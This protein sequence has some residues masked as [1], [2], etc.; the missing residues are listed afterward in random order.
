MY[1]ISFKPSFI[2]QTKHLEKNLLALLY[3]KMELLKD[4]QNHRVLKIH[5]LHGPL[6]GF[7]SFSLNY[8][9]R[10]IFEFISQN[11]IVLVAMGGHEIYK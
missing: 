3:K 4:S 8:K 6:R 1:R 7:Y 9:T 2:K 11:E 10:V 5:K